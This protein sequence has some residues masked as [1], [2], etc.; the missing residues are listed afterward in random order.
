MLYIPQYPQR[1]FSERFFTIELLRWS[2]TNSLLF[3]LFRNQRNQEMGGNHHHHHSNSFEEDDEDSDTLEN[4]LDNDIHDSDSE[5]GGKSPMSS[6]VASPDSNNN[7][8]NSHGN[9]NN[10]KNMTTTAMNSDNNKIHQIF[11]PS[12]LHSS[13]QY[14]HHQHH[15]QNHGIGF[16]IPSTITTSHLTQKPSTNSSPSKFMMSDILKKSSSPSPVATR[17]R[18][19]SPASSTMLLNPYLH[20]KAN[21]FVQTR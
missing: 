10:D 13:S 16:R 1:T 2:L 17:P 12:H 6:S 15:L 18:T 14:H 21:L 19:L 8:N 9:N 3:L 7:N 20:T 4:I 5:H 11:D